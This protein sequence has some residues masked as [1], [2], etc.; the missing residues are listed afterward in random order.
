[1]NAP[2]RIDDHAVAIRRARTRLLLA[3]VLATL[4]LYRREVVEHCDETIA[5]LEA[6]SAWCDGGKLPKWAD[7]LAQAH[8]VSDTAAEDTPEHTAAMERLMAERCTV[9][10]CEKAIEVL[11]R[12]AVLPS[13]GYLADHVKRLALR[14]NESSP[15]HSSMDLVMDKF[16]ATLAKNGLEVTVRDFFS[17]EA[18]S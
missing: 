6:L 11:V 2:R 18:R 13:G 3:P 14:L 10:F 7:E 15:S 4:R 12:L 1:M 9:I 8:A 16:S 5:R 17:L